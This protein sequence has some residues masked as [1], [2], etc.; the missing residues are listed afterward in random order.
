MRESN[1]YMFNFFVVFII[2]G[3]FISANLIVGILV[4]QILSTGTL[5]EA[6]KSSNK[7]TKQRR[8][9]QNEPNTSEFVEVFYF[10]FLLNQFKNTKKKPFLNFF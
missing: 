6:I 8:N 10:V 1:I 3:V 9:Q 2:F 5:S 4:K 7:T